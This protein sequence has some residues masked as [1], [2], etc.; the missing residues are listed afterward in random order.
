MY[1]LDTNVIS[2]MRKVKQGKANPNV[3]SW[4]EKTDAHL[5]YTSTI[6]LMELTRGVLRMERKDPQ[7]GKNL[8]QWLEAVSTELFANRIL[9][10]DPETAAICAALHIP[11]PTPENDA[12]IAACALQHKLVLV[13]RNTADFADCGVKI[14]NPFTSE[15]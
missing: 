4:L 15:S 1:L 11:D 10:I 14:F 3:L 2:E 12:W 13:T 9:S 8:R 6:N 7:Q 5:L